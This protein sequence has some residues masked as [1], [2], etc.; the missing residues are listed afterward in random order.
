MAR[1]EGPSVE[2]LS[3]LSD[4]ELLRRHIEAD[5]PNRA[6][7]ELFARYRDVVTQALEGAGLAHHDAMLRL[8]AVFIRALDLQRGA[9][10]E[11][12]LKEHLLATV[13]DVV[14]A[15]EEDYPYDD[16]SPE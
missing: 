12:P 4:E 1:R 13:A 15:H 8:A 7:M 5:A 3:E 14:A 16:P 9:R 10:L 6:F 2:D 11:R